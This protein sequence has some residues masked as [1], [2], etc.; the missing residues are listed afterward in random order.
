M[1]SAY[2]DFR[3]ANHFL[4]HIILVG[5][6][7]GTANYILNGNLN[8]IQW[9]IQSMSTSFIIGYTSV[10]IGLNK[11][12][13][14]SLFKTKSKFYI[15]ILTSFILAGLLATE[16]EHAIRSLV[17][18]SQKFQPLSAGKMYIYNCIISLIM[19]LSFFQNYFTIHKNHELG[20]NQNIK[21]KKQLDA[22]GVITNLPLKQ[23]E[24]IILI[25]IENVV[26]FE[27]YDNYSFVYDLDGTRRLCD[28]S[29]LFLQKRLSKQFSRVHR[30]YIV[31]KNHIK[32]IKPHINGRY[33]I[34]FNSKLSPITSS[35]SYSTIIKK[36][37]KIE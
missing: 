18:H 37:I 35:K 26:Y 6:G 33:N 15:I 1:A 24:N 16:I 20:E 3:K 25:H 11:S 27:A 14:K 28:Y 8:W 32:Q 4:P 29:L 2:F 22:K 36:L 21:N 30:K 34:F 7:I 19:G 12:W 10:I 13:L 5:L 31:N 9:C 17:F 23:G